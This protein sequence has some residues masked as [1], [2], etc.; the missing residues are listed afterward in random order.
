[1]SEELSDAAAPAAIA[2]QEEAGAAPRAPAG[3]KR[4]YAVWFRHFRVYSNFFFANAT[5]AIFEPLFLMLAVGLGVG[6]Y[7]KQTFN[8]GLDYASFMAPGILAMTSLYT[9]A[10]EASY[11]TFIRY[12]YQKTYH[13]MLATPLTRRDIFLGELLWCGTKGMLF[14]SLVGL[15]LFLFGK[16]HSP[17]AVLIPAVG[18]VTSVAFAGL[19]F[20][21]TSF[22]NSINHFQY[23][24]TVVLTPL[25]FFSG[26]MFPV[27]ELPAN[28]AYIA[29]ALPMF[30]VI[31]TFRLVVS[32]PEHSSVPWA[33]ACPFVLV[34]MAVTLGY[35]GVRRMEGKL[36]P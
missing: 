21:V 7:I 8:G 36:K 1:M 2:A 9:A 10:F 20:F 32:G 5:P 19:S 34:G 30:H 6:N 15:V 22:V 24:F 3:F 11:G 35:I 28:L 16:V 17:A 29:Y 12:M 14:S 4:V 18:F 33:W 13:G 31:E 26:L 23:Y 25:T 27:Q